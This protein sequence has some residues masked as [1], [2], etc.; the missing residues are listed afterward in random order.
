MRILVAD[1]QPRVR[2][3]IRVLLA[4][5]AGCEIVGETENAEQLL[6]KAKAPSFFSF[7]DRIVGDAPFDS[8]DCRQ[9]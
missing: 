6:I 7:P 1:G 9:L 4:R 5:R 2:F 3:A 8:A